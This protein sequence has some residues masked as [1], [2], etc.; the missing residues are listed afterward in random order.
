MRTLLTRY[1]RSCAGALIA[2]GQIWIPVPPG[3]AP[4]DGRTDEA[5]GGPAPGHPERLC[6]EVPLSEAE[7]TW[8]RQL[9][10]APGPDPYEG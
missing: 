9:L 5:P 7:M 6:P 10:G 4:Q 1:L 2:F 3:P 8:G